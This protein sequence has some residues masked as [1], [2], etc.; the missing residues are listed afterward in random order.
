MVLFKV[1]ASKFSLPKVETMR[2]SYYLNDNIFQ[3][4]SVLEKISNI[5]LNSL[6]SL[7]DP[8]RDKMKKNRT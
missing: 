5:S 2:K 6:M 8:F 1:T 4:E 7:L 3:V